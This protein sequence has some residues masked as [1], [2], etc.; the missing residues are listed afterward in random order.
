MR[1]LHRIILHDFKA[2]GI[3]KALRCRIA[4]A[5]V[6]AGRVRAQYIAVWLR[7]VSNRL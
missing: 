1:Q 2:Q 3:G 4:F 6:N 7:I 5:Q